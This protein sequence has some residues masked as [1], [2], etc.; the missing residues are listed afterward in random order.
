MTAGYGFEQASSMIR[1]IGFRHG[2]WDMDMVWRS[3]LKSMDG[4]S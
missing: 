1:L 4:C 2:I 3:G